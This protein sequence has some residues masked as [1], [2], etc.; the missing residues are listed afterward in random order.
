M[1]SVRRNGKIFLYLTLL[2][3]DAFRNQLRP[4][5]ISPLHVNSL[6]KIQN[7][8]FVILKLLL[9]ILPVRLSESLYS[10]KV[11]GEAGLAVD[12]TNQLA[13]SSGIQKSCLPYSPLEYANKADQT[14]SPPLHFTERESKRRNTSSPL[15]GYTFYVDADVS[16]ELQSKVWS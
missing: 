15:F 4:R 7:K 12:D 8:H 10:I 1:D 3:L 2:F 16:S 9:F 6:N 13:P 11:V 14:G 5:R